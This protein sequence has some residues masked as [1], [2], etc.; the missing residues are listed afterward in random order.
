MRTKAYG[1]QSRVDLAVAVHSTLAGQALADTA[2]D[3]IAEV[4]AF[5]TATDMTSSGV[6]L[7]VEFFATASS[8]GGLFVHDANRRLCVRLTVTPGATPPST[9]VDADCVEERP[10]GYRDVDL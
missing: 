6:E 3:A 9:M 7:T 5:V 10:P 8:G 2:T 4:G 1:G